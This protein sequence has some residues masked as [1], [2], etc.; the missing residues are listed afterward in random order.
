[1][2]GGV[3]PLPY[4]E[5]FP[6]GGRPH[7]HKIVGRGVTPPPVVRV[8]AVLLKYELAGFSCGIAGTCVGNEHRDGEKCGGL[9]MDEKGGRGYHPPTIIFSGGGRPPWHEIF[10]KGGTALDF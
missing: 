7:C 4:S 6:G 2:R 3:T 5:K 1:L 10:G 9:L 8:R